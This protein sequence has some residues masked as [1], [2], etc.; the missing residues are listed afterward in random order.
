MSYS[1]CSVNDAKETRQAVCISDFYANFAGV[2]INRTFHYRVSFLNYAAI[3]VVAVAALCAFWHKSAANA[4]V[5]FALMIV[6]VLMVERIVH[7]AY[8]LTAD[9]RLRVSK[10]RFS[11]RVEIRLADIVSVETVHGRLLPVRYVLVRYG[12]GHELAVQP[13]N[14]EAFIEEIRKRQKAL[15]G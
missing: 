4:V 15:E 5:G 9:G 6:V 2:M 10:G 12:A 8:T 13:A 3:I 1:V 11:R 14:E 7:T